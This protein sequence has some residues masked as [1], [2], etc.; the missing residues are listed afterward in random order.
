[1]PFTNSR[2]QLIESPP[3]VRSSMGALVVEISTQLEVRPAGGL[4]R[5]SSHVTQSGRMILTAHS[6]AQRSRYSHAH[7]SRRSSAHHLP[8]ALTH[9]LLAHGA[10]PLAHSAQP[11]D[12]H[13]AHLLAAHSSTRIVLKTEIHAKNTTEKK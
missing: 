4:L 13:A 6:S 5:P 12:A 10:Q 1:M 3:F 7:R 8:T 2:L 11:L 9:S